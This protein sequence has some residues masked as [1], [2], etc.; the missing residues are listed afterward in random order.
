MSTGTVTVTPCDAN[1]T[2]LITLQGEHDLATRAALKAQTDPIWP[3][4]TVAIIDLSDA[5]FV[6]SGLIRWLLH[7]ECELEAAG[8]STLSIVEGTPGS[9]ADRIFGIL[10]MPHVLACYPT[11]TEALQQ[12]PTGRLQAAA[13]C[14]PS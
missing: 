10:H 4:C 1:G 12:A 8:A 2:W 5:D 11:R 6:D 3:F 7:V 13:L 14:A 9:V